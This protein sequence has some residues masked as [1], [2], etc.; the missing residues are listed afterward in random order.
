MTI[1]VALLGVLA[2]C[3]E[4]RAVMLPLQYPDGSAVTNMK[5]EPVMAG[6]QTYGSAMHA[7]ATALYESARSPS[8]ATCAR[9]GAVVSEP[10]N[11]RQITGVL[12]T[13]AVGAG[14]VMGGIGAMDYGTAA[15]EGKLGTN[16]TQSSSATQ[17]STATQSSSSAS[18]ASAAAS[19]AAASNS[20]SS[21]NSGG[22]KYKGGKHGYGHGVY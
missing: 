4:P 17:S 14:T 3:G 9:V 1:G 18:A 8:C 10:S 16:V 15:R 19:A 5:G 22:E 2:G 13:G 6:Y 21:S 7:N 20:D 12:G 11:L